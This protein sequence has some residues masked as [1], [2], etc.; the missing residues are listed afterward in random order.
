MKKLIQNILKTESKIAILGMGV[1]GIAIK[2]YLVKHG[3]KNLTLCDEKN[4]L[5]E[6]SNDF[7]LRI[8]QNAFKNLS[9]FDVI[10]RSPG[11][12]KNHPGLIE[13]INSKTLVTSATKIFFEIC[14]CKIIG[15]TGTKGKGTTSSLIYEILKTANRDVYLGGNIGNSPLNFLDKLD[16]NS[17]VVL[18]MS[19]FQLHD[20]KQSPH[21]SIVLNTTQ[22]HLDYHADIEEYL[23]A[24]ESIVSNQTP[25]DFA[26]FN[27]DY[28]Y[29]KRYSKLTN[30]KKFWVSKNSA[31]NQKII[32][33]GF[34]DKDS[35]VLNIDGNKNII[36]NINEVGLIGPHNIEN[37]LPASLACKILGIENKVIAQTIKRFR[38]LPHRLE[39]IKEINGIAYYNDSF[40][41]TP[42]TCI[43]AIKSFSKPIT[44]IIGGSEKHSDFTELG[45]TI[46]KQE[47][48]KTVILMGETGPRILK[49]IQKAYGKT[50][51]MK[52]PVEIISVN[53][54]EEAFNLAHKKAGNNSVVL[55]SPASASF[56]MFENYKVRGKTFRKWVESL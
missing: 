22:D 42:E 46:I 30:G 53:G 9:E 24:K 54:Y 33:G 34:V 6:Y 32:N 17:I 31:N 23:S 20:L 52:L 25:E 1:E 26:I 49:T 56:D 12:H 19:S 47:N 51:L 28:P 10:F 5:E 44:L 43:A 15:I 29:A 7:N 55:L 41:T 4:N 18:E 38:G 40:S 37:I 36:G 45:K 3:F 11:I 2:E 21:I 50:N 27:I 48:L 13:A 39:F 14:P 8:G 35:L 16:T